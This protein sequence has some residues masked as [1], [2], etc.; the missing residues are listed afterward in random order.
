MMKDY[1]YMK[2]LANNGCSLILNAASYNISQLK[3][4]ASQCEE[5]GSKL[6]LKNASELTFE[7]L[8]ELS[9]YKSIVLDLS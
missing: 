6:I 2:V 7:T 9:H 4:I 5:E 8:R 1:E 3:N